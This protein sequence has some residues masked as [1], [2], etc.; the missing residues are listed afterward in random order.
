M[1][2]AGDEPPMPML[3]PAECV[4]RADEA[5]EQAVGLTDAVA[6]ETL[7][8]IAAAYEK[9]ARY[10]ALAADQTDNGQRH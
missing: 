9:L 5:R 10:A 8:D 6:R 1:N 4:A 2:G 7:L 3:S